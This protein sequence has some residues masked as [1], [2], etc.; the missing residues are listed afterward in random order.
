[1]ATRTRALVSHWLPQRL[2]NQ[3]KYLL[4]FSLDEIDR[5]L[6]RRNTLVPTRLANFVGDGDFEEIGD[7]FSRYFVELG[8]LRPEH[9][10]LD[11]GCGMGRMA[12]PL[13]EYLTSG[14]Y[15]G[16]DI[17]PAGI[18]WCQQ[19]YS[20]TH[21]NF[22]FQLAD[23]HNRYYNPRGRFQ[24][25]EYRFPFSDQ[26]FDFVFLTSVFTHMLPPGMARYL[27]EIFR[28]I[29]K[30]GKCLITLFLLNDQTKE[31]IS[32][33]LSSRDFGFSF[34]G[35]RVQNPDIPEDAVAYEENYIRTLLAET[36]FDVEHVQYGSWCGRRRY[37]SYQDIVV[38]RKSR[39]TLATP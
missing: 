15:E 9:R 1:L 5:L 4:N 25:A 7:E 27:S 18:S 36:G 30:D 39:I 11:I 10:V 3:L 23:V 19:S 35:C 16:L 6:G 29:R 38:V 13:T 26:E 14:S 28:T 20:P 17:V 2:K 37:L 21:P 12:R 24:A 31:L 34:D 22:H 32:S 33:G 8:G